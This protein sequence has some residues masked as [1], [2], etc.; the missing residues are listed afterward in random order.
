VASVGIVVHRGREEAWALAGDAAAWLAERGHQVRLPPGDAKATGL[1]ASVGPEEQFGEGLDLM[2]SLGGDGTMLR[3]VELV[4]PYGVPVLGVNVGHLGYL[5]T[6]EPGE[7]QGSLERFFA[8]SY[9]VEE[10]M[11]LEVTAE[12]ASTGQRF[13][14][15]TAMNEAWL[16]KAEPGHTVHMSVE[17][18]GQPFTTYAADGIIVATP[19]GS[20]AY[21]LSVRGPILSPTLE[22]MV[23][24]P[25][26]PHQLFDFSL[27]VDPSQHIRIEVLGER[28]AILLVDGRAVC[29]VSAGDVVTCRKGNHVARL[30]TFGGRDFH[31]ILKSKFGLQ[32][33]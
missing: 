15:L 5:T 12:V 10:R 26:A 8:G 33:R 20:T 14:G 18:G 21:N 23:M 3:A 6:R 24:T 27:V 32:D 9:D 22:A 30:V 1:T 17:V 19:T 31:R 11:T 4:V 7:L 29:K 25:V 16:E 28:V 2:L 13:E